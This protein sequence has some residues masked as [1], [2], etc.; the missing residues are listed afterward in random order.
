MLRLN[1]LLKIIVALVALV[2]H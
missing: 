2:R 1:D